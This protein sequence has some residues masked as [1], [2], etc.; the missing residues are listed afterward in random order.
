M[1]VV[2]E[3]INCPA[4]LVW[5]IQQLGKSSIAKAKARP[6]IVSLWDDP[7]HCMHDLIQQPTMRDD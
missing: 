6:R 4:M 1:D 7:H 3:F 5:K 2:I